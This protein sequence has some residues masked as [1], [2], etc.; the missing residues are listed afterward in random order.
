MTGMFSQTQV[1]K[2]AAEGINVSDPCYDPPFM[3]LPGPVC[4]EPDK[5]LFW[6]MNHPTAAGAQVI[7][8]A[9]AQAAVGA[10]LPSR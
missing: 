1:A 8:A 4:A 7:G 3:G 9:F 2:A 5:H 6:D 10:A